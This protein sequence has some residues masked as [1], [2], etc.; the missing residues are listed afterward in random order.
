MSGECPGEC[1]AI[2]YIAF[3]DAF[4]MIQEGIEN[5]RTGGVTLSL[6]LDL[7]LL[8]LFHLFNLHYDSFISPGSTYTTDIFIQCLLKL[9]KS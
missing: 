2:L 1:P 8:L 7:N 4:S 9:S 5:R 6:H 3:L